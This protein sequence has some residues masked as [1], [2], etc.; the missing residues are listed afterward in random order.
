M[1]CAPGVSQKTPLPGVG[2]GGVTSITLPP[3]GPFPFRLTPPTPLPRTPE[4]SPE[5]L[6][7]PKSSSQAF[8]LGKPNPSQSFSDV[9]ST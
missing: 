3:L 7:A 9:A 1:P 4:S 5:E 6:L 2:W 8:L